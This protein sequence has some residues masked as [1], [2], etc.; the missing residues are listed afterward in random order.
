MLM[1][2]VS[3][4]LTSAFNKR[5]KF[6]RKNPNAKTPWPIPNLFRLERANLSISGFASR[7]SFRKRNVFPS[8]L[9][10]INLFRTGLAVVSGNTL[11]SPMRQPTGKFSDHLHRGE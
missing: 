3:H 7:L 10:G 9:S 1:K 11:F 5:N 8:H 6:E 2:Q 4:V